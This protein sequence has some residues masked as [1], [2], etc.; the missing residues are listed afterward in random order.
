MPP[1][2]DLHELHAAAITSGI[3]RDALLSGINRSFTSS[4]PRLSSRAAQ[5]LRDL[6]EIE[7]VGQLSDG[8]SPLR[9][10]LLNASRLSALR[11]EEKVFQR[12][13]ALL[14]P[15]IVA[16]QTRPIAPPAPPS[17]APAPSRGLIY[18]SANSRDVQFVERLRRHLSPLEQQGLTIWDRSKL[19]GGDLT[20]Q[21]VERKLAE[22]KLLVPLLSA[23]YLA[24]SETYG[25]LSRALKRPNLELVP[26]LLRPCLYQSLRE[27]SGRTILPRS[28]KAVTSH[29][30]VEAALAGVVEDLQ[31]IITD[32]MGGPGA[33][34]TSPTP[35]MEAPRA[36][37]R[38]MAPVATS[39]MPAATASSDVAEP[40]EPLA[41]IFS[42]SGDPKRLYVP[43]SQLR[44]IKSH[45]H[46][47]GR[48]LVIEGPSKIGKTTALRQAIGDLPVRWLNAIEL[49][50]ERDVLTLI[51][52]REIEG[53]VVID[54]AQR[55]SD[56]AMERLARRMRVEADHRAPSGKLIVV[57][58]PG[59]GQRL[60]NR[61]RD[62]S[63]RFDEVRML[64]QPDEKIR[65]L[66]DLVE[67]VARLRFTYKESI[68]RASRGSFQLAREICF[69][70][71]LAAEIDEVPKVETAIPTKLADVLREV[72]SALRR[73][74]D[75]LVL[76]LATA[77]AG[78]E[79]PGA[80]LAFLWKLSRTEED[81]VALSALKRDYPMLSWDIW[82]S[83]QF[84]PV[85]RGSAKLEDGGAQGGPDPKEIV[86]LVSG[87]L[88]SEDPLFRF[89]LQGLRW[90]EWEDLASRAGISIER[91]DDDGQFTQGLFIAVGAQ[92]AVSV[93]PEASK[94]LY[95]SMTYPFWNRDAAA[96]RDL[97]VG[98]YLT[99]NEMK[100]L[101]VRAGVS[102]HQFAPGDGA[103]GPAWNSLLE[104]AT[105]Q[106]KLRE[107]I[108]AVLADD[109]A[110]SYHDSIKKTLK[111]LGVEPSDS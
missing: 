74:F 11:S 70:S 7:S 45:V 102:I 99:I 54:N 9:T 24:D 73:Q 50:G 32:L 39:T 1:T 63:G 38:P 75:D 92:A 30:D 43:P 109:Y 27:L 111:R 23:D 97:L 16:A 49:D 2:I 56:S 78:S 14:D 52:E 65:E 26:V 3:D 48:G 88:V 104:I 29:S 72:Q 47:P 46:S 13:L 31:A 6:H 41:A 66:V 64:R 68:V 86:Q 76:S 87:R 17:A 84:E 37:T 94:S 80:G 71:A 22:A 5:I 20:N 18:I 42:R 105:R 4:I 103:P 15:E 35:I 91:L 85:G 90:E 10:W 98:A 60:T 40:G 101:A 53:L 55:L 77:D 44:R 62:L 89:Y 57:S 36:A 81:G 59:I 58:T 95:D 19:R 61:Q 25:E 34:P 69:E 106:K 83:G 82:E 21:V 93:R 100:H 33:E 96:L 12:A 79:T 107:L 110:G 67:R 8:T 28:K 108:N 51:E